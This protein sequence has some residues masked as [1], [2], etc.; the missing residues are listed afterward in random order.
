MNYKNS[1]D[2]AWQILIKNKVSSL[3]VSVEK[4]CKAE[5]IKLFTYAEGERIIR[6]LKLYENSI[7]NDAFSINRVVFY[8]DTKPKTRQR[9]SV[10][11]EIGH[12]ILHSPSEATVLNREICSN[13]SP[14]EQEANIFASRILAPLSILHFLNVSTAEE[15]S[16]ICNISF[17]AAEIRYQRLCEIRNRDLEMK[18]TKGYGCFL[19]SPLERAVYNNFKAY[20]SENKRC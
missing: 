2:A 14:L 8:D 1:R 18:K 10:A 16:E 9:F 15:I 20:I 12:I 3:P 7:G 17:V 19:L 13:D 4:I 6:K 11:H 5:K